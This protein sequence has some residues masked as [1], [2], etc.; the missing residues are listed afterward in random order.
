[1]SGQQHP[2]LLATHKC[3][4]HACRGERGPESASSQAAG[5]GA[6]PST[7]G[8]L[9]SAL[10]GDLGGLSGLLGAAGINTAYLFN[11]HKSSFWKCLVVLL[12]RRDWG[13]QWSLGVAGAKNDFLWCRPM[14]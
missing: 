5:G 1:M 9:L 10:G 12:N 2:P 13:A 8:G 7:G 3:P 14:A 11:N 6:Q 4:F